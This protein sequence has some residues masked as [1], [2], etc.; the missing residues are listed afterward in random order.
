MFKFV[1]TAVLFVGTS[2][3]CFSR[4]IPKNV[5]LPFGIVA[6]P[7]VVYAGC[8]NI[9]LLLGDFE[10]ALEDFRKA[11]LYLEYCESPEISEF[12]IL[13][14]QIVAYDNLNQRDKCEQALGS[15]LLSMQN[16]DDEE[17]YDDDGAEIDIDFERMYAESI[18]MMKRLAVLA[19]SDDVR[20]F[21]LS[22]VDEMDD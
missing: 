15:L 22:I 1:V 2:Y 10:F 17:E 16:F 12:M 9:H 14:G 5:E 19:S 3:S 13:F 11:S 6:S 21:L 20:E 7:A 18:K 8:G 4:D